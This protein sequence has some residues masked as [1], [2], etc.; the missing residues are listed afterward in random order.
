MISRRP[1]TGNATTIFTQCS[2]PF[3]KIIIIIIIVIIIIIIITITIITIRTAT[4]KTTA[5]IENLSLV[6]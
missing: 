5:T 2:P 3:P 4:I 1:H 6:V